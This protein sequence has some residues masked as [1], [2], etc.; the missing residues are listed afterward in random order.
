MHSQIDFGYP[1]FLSYGHLAM[2][3][4]AVPL[5]LLAIWRKWSRPLIVIVSALAL[6]SV[7]AFFA[8]R[9]GLDPNGRATLPTQSFLSSGA[10]NVL[11][12][13]AGTGRSSLM[14]LEARPRSTL[15]ALD[16][17]GESYEQHFGTPRLG[18]QRLLDN[19]RAA[20]VADRVAIQAGDMR[21]MP[22]ETG[23]FDAIVSAYAIDHLNR[24][25]IRDSLAEA[26]RV[27][28]PNGEFL[29]IVIHKDFWANYTWGLA[30]LHMRMP[31]EEFWPQALRAAGFDVVEQGF[32]P[33]TMYLLARKT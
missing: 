14:V 6:W 26:A 31:G 7:S 29:L 11:D 24:E 25:G 33:A 17:F 12:M 21:R 28:K 1:W 23:S 19:L 10:G 8:V 18:R 32:K 3:A 27:L 30:L 5:M 13:G 9:F 22:L 4:I 16:E 15:V 20:G 2:A